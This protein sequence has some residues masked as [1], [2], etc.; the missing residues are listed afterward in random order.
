[1]NYNITSSHHILLELF[2][3]METERYI[4]LAMEFASNGEIFEL[5]KKEG[6][7]NETQARHMFRQI[8]SAMEYLHQKRIVHRDLKVCVMVFNGFEAKS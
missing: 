2:Q 5:L 1:M 3:V 4:Y 7:R 6:R 8:I